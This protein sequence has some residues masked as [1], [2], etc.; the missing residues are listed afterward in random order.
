MGVYGSLQS[1]E[2]ELIFRNLVFVIDKILKVCFCLKFFRL[3]RGTANELDDRIRA[4]GTAASMIEV[5]LEKEAAQKDVYVENE[6]LKV[7]GKLFINAYEINDR[8]PRQALEDPSGVTAGG[9]CSTL[10]F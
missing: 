7:R 2:I 3:A 10:W 9:V 8:C 5:P 1:Y 4:R 6:E